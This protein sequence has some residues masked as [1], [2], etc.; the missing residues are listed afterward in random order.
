MRSLKVYGWIGYRRETKR[1]QSRE[2]VAAKSMSE[3]ARCAGYG[4]AR[5]MWNLCETG[6]ALEIAIA[7]SKPGTVFWC[8]LDGSHNLYIDAGTGTPA[9]P[10]QPKP[11]PSLFVKWIGWPAKPQVYVLDPRSVHDDGLPVYIYALVEGK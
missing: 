1:G 6:N 7:T 4:S 10:H 2:I 9:A 5:Q 8:E 11:S 3:A